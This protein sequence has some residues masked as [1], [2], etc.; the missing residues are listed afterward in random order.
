MF[1][2][3]KQRVEIRAAC[4]EDYEGIAALE[5]AHGLASKPL[6]EWRRLWTDN[7]YYEELGPKW[8]IGWVLH[9]RGRIVGSS[10]NIPL[11]YIFR[12]KKILVASG[13]GW[14]VE[15]QYRGYAP[16]LADEYFSQQNV[17]VFLNNTVNAKA[18]DAFQTFGSLRVPVGDWTTAAF[19]VTKHRG[20]AE[21]ALRIK[22]I[23]QPRLLSYPAGLALSLKDRF[24]SKRPA[25]SDI[26][27]SLARDFDHRF[28]TF[29]VRLQER[30]AEFL[31]VRSREVLKWHFGPSLASGG[32]WVLTAAASGTMEAYAIFQRRDEPRYGLKRMRMVDF[33]AFER[34]DEYCAAIVRRASEE[35][36]AQGIHVL[37][38]VGCGLE[39]TRIF[40][41]AAPYRRQLPSWSFFYLANNPELASHLS[42][43]EAWAPS[44]YDG[45]SSL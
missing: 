27:V 42:K 20:F 9:D 41:Q 43:P 7:P 32:I 38:H 3:A 6:D 34:R 15:D 1:A 24:T 2:L 16:L 23:P 5:T 17:D 37:E 14:V 45:D 13:R 8:P 25:R 28:D 11:P 44:S 18:A 39:K 22:E 4:F 30:S 19:A 12:G 36:R 29:W 35:C 21:S 31:A 33:Q 40:E 26:D 10:G